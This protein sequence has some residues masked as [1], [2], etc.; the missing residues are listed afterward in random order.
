[1]KINHKVDAIIDS[2]GELQDSSDYV[3]L[4]PIVE[5]PE[6]DKLNWQITGIDS[7]LENVIIPGLQTDN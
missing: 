1:V 4:T 7:K 3:Y 2:Q 5:D 6:N